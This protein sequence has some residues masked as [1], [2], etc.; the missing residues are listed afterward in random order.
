MKAFR[1]SVIAMLLLA[2]AVFANSAYIEKLTE[3]FVSEV[4]LISETDPIAASDALTELHQKFK[5]AEKIISIT[6][7]HDDLT[8]IEE[9]FAEMRG[10]V[11]AEDMIE[12]IK[13]K[14]RLKSAFE[15]LGRL[16]G[17]NIDS[18]I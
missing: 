5:R 11:N 12:V 17:I 16:S 18:I 15:H 3:K 4:E 6:T 14:S 8:S 2:A 9:G 1:I 7:S 10:A 13:I